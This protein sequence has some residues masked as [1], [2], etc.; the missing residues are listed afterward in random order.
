[1]K[2]FTMPL[3]DVS[4]TQ[5]SKAFS[6]ALTELLG[7]LYKV[8]IADINFSPEDKPEFDRAEM[9]IRVRYS[10]YDNHDD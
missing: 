8:E 2:G 9:H 4:T 3:R 7:A 5:I 6:K 10:K 1:M